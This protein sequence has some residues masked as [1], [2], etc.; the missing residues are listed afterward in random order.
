M[1]NINVRGI[2]DKTKE[3]LRVRAAQAGM[4]LE[5]FARRELV[6]ASMALVNEPRSIVDLADR[7]F[8]AAHG[9]ELDIPPRSTHRSPPDIGNL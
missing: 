2:P 1:P 5:A 8:G 9:V 3:A 7:H 4:S 6:K